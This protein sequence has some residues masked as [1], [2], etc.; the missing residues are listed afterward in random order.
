MVNL[1]GKF[2]SNIYLQYI[3]CFLVCA[4][5]IFAVV[6]LTGSTLIWNSDG[7]TQH[8][9]ALIYWRR[10]L[11]GLILHHHIWAQWDWN[12]GLGQDTIQTFS[13]YVMGDIFTYPSI[14]FHES[15]MAAYYSIMIVVRLFLAGLS[16][17]FA[18]KHLI[19]TNKQWTILVASFVY[20]YS[21]YASYVTFAHPFFLNPLIIMPLL[22][23]GLHRAMISDKYG[24]L[25]I[26]TAWALFNNFYLG[27]IMGLGVAIYWVIFVSVDRNLFKLTKIIKV[28]I[29]VAAGALT[30]A[31]LFLPSFYQL[32][33]STR[34]SS[35]LANGM[36]W[37]PL[38]YY[39]TLPGLSLSDYARP[40]WVTGGF[41]AIGLI[42]ITWSIR[43]FKKYK[44]I[45]ITLLTGFIILLSPILAAL[46]NGGSSPSNRWT[47]L[48]MMPIAFTVIFMLNHLRELTSH[49][50]IWWTVVG[51][52]VTFSLFAGNK[53]KFTYDLGSVMVI[54]FATLL[55]FAIVNSNQNLRFKTSILATS[56]ILVTGLNAVIMMRDRHTNQMSSTTSTLIS[57]QTAHQLT[58][59]QKAYKQISKNDTHRTLVDG[60]LRTYTGKSPA[61]NLP[62]LAETKNINS[63]WSL[64]NSSLNEL[65]S[66]LEN[67][68][69]NPNDTTN[70]ADFRS[71]M[72]RYLGVSRLFLN[73]DESVP[74][75]Y[76]ATGRQI[77]SQTEYVAN[78]TVPLIYKAAGTL[79]TAQFNSLSTSQK[80]TALLS[81]LVTNKKSS[82]PDTSL[83][84][85][86]VQ[87][88]TNL[89]PTNADKLTK[90]Q[91]IS[92]STPTTKLTP[93]TITW[94]TNKS[95]KGYELHAQLTNIRYSAGSFSERHKK[96]L[97]YY[98][99]NHN[100]EIM[101]AGQE[102]DLRYN[103]TLYNFSWLRKNVMSYAAT[104]GEFDIGLNYDGVSNTFNQTG[105]NDL[106][107]YTPRS[108]TTLNLGTITST[109]E[110]N[111]S[112]SLSLP[113]SGKTSFDITL[114]AVP[115]GKSVDK[116]IAKDKA[117]KD[118]TMTKNGVTAKYTS[119]KSDILAT[120]IP[121]SKGWHLAGSK[122]ALP[123]VNKG[124]I[125]IPV[126]KGKNNIKLIY[127][128][129][130]LTMGVF[131]SIFGI[132]IIGLILIV[133]RFL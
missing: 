89:L 69:S 83:L 53:F 108:S 88:K 103:P 94:P 27:A 30:S 10:M 26:M 47:F 35:K 100:E 58:N 101:M 41:L 18:A 67:N 119:S 118:I 54:Y 48:L 116:T 4:C 2:R 104:T 90:T 123:K 95:I 24:M 37:Y 107:F 25:S 49:D 91:H 77:N 106:S 36:T 56:L 85:K 97:D 120:T 96:A 102:T 70:T 111:N 31:V 44:I 51:I 23:Y 132:I 11:R 109:D 128:T 1:W 130:L 45:N 19:R 14:L 68:T 28:I 125:G 131:A 52:I 98:I 79:N 127:R 64:Q 105:I 122:S 82:N 40:Y 113:T 87:I 50:F 63:Y 121:Y 59:T 33:V 117:A 114:W 61:D 75:G 73:D 80:E 32:T 74:N 17:I 84:S 34:S 133:E 12:L 55:I 62:I 65:N 46:M 71:L 78:S 129:P 3:C 16:F 81:N 9:P 6:P 66:S 15:Q 112:I 8:Y 72:L 5:I 13:Y 20:M 92:V 60:Q 7:I 57:S 39:F 29:S 115:T 21:G 86:V 22:I 99:E 124:F 110:D 42:G 126:H 76:E 93:T 43:R 38:S